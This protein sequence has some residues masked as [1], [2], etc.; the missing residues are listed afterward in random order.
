MGTGVKLTE[1]SDAILFG[2]GPVM[3]H[4]ALTAAAYLKKINFGLQVINLP[5]LNKIDS[6]W[7]KAIIKDQKRIFVLEDHS[8]I[9]GLAD[10][11]L[12]E[13]VSNGLICGKE[14][15]NLGIK[16]IPNAELRLKSLNTTSLMV[17]H[18][19]KEFQE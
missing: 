9:G 4:E 10:R 19:H 16:N 6:D 17:N 11:L 18:L 1:G 15:T 3:L 5:W 7:L 12:N 2:Y 13:S 14:F 8:A